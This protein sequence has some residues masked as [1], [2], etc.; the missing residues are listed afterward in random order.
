[1]L[2]HGMGRAWQRANEISG[3]KWVKTSGTYPLRTPVTAIR[4]GWTLKITGELSNSNI[5]VR[6]FSGRD[7]NPTIMPVLRL[8]M[9][10]VTK[11]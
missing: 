8:A 1:M 9:E 4:T 6:P 11:R 5:V 2:D 7:S 10:P 3:L